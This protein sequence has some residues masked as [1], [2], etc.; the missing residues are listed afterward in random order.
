VNILTIPV[1]NL[2]R[3][4]LRTI[5]LAVIFSIGILSV[6]ALSFISRAVGENLEEKMNAYGANILVTP[7][8][9]TLPVG[10]GGMSLGDV[11]VELKY[12]PREETVRAIRSIHMKD[13]IS[14]AAPKFVVLAR[15]DGRPL[16]VIG[17]DWAE[18]LG[19]KSY[20]S[21]AQG[22]RPEAPDQ[23][24]A[25]SAAARTLGLGPG[26]AIEVEGRAFQVSGILAPTGGDDDGVVFADIGTLQQ[27]SGRGDVAH[28]VEVSALCAGCPV[29]EIVAEIEHMLP[30]AEVK[31]L[32]QVV[33]Q[34]MM[35]VH[36][37]NSL[38]LSVSLVILLTACVMIGLSVFSAVNER[39]HEI[40]VM[41]SLGFSRFSVFV[42]FSMEAL[43]TGMLAGAI[44]YAGG[45]AVSGKVLSVLEMT[46]A[47]TLSFDPAHFLLTMAAVAL[48][49]MAASAYPAFKAARMD[50]SRA[51]VVL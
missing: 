44:G 10:Y 1:R 2:R 11:S 45:F 15:V 36:F 9:E 42:V 39:K 4:A 17:V 46:R 38:A 14:A 20:W 29:E 30:G 16:G 41:R 26:T 19:I 33:K 7:R 50:P 34:R 8:A 6:V 28:F 51:L 18:E 12:L 22:A 49:S 23:V 5:L 48:L 37:V 32:Q 43:L 27:A 35:T 21:V 40:G 47:A 3:K 31:A 25:G 24:L 13:R